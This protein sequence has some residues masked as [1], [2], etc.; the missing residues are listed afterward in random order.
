L[1]YARALEV[2]DDDVMSK[3]ADWWETPWGPKQAEATLLLMLLL[4]RPSI[5]IYRSPHSR[6][7][8]IQPT[9]KNVSIN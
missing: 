4:C 8:G 1:Y 5:I 6:Y 7:Q 9:T 3:S 2:V